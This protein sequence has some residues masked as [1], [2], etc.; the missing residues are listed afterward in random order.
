MHT[1][2]TRTLIEEVPTD[3]HSPMKFLCDD[4]NLYYCKYRI[5]SSA[6][7][8]DFLTYELV[9][10]VLLRALNLPTPDIALVEM[11]VGSYR[12]DQLSA[13]R[14]FIRPGVICF[15]SRALPNA[16]LVRQTEAICSARTFRTLLNPTD[17]IRLAV[18]DLWTDNVDRG[19]AFDGGYN[20]N[21]LRV[22]EGGKTRFVAFD[23]AFTFG[24]E[25][26]LRSFKPSWPVLPANRLFNSP[27]Y[28][29]V[30][31]HIAPARR[32]T[33]ANECLSLCYERGKEALQTA[34]GDLPPTWATLPSLLERMTDFLL[35][36]QRRIAIQALINQ[37]IP[38]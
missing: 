5:R 3:G 8:L 17:L 12:P 21:L 28:R 18:F 29:A 33:V 16:D 38:F 25:H 19:R 14:R 35:N 4:G 36:D 30:V 2:R 11:Q 13:N 9:S 34:F 31:K 22:P 27:Y 24:G 7:E 32:F 15:G 6:V 23:N 20:Y 1:C 37:S 10:H 26:G